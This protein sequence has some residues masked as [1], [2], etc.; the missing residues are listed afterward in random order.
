MLKWL[1]GDRK[2][3]AKPAPTAS[4]QAPTPPTGTPPVKLREAMGMALG[5]HQAG[6]WAEADALYRQILA[7][8]PDNPD[9]LHLRGVLA[10]QTGRQD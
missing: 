7:A 8:E 4:A 5:H 1:L 10:H 2:V 3:A 6:R 9:A